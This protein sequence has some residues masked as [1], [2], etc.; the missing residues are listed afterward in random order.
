MIFSHHNAG[1]EG[2][3][4]KIHWNNEQK[5]RNFVRKLCYFIP[6]N[7]AVLTLSL[8]YSIYCVCL[9]NYDTS[10][11]ILQFPLYTPFNK[12]TVIG[13][14]GEWF[15]QFTLSFSYATCMSSLT[16]YFVCCCFYIGTF[17]DHFDEICRLVKGDADQIQHEK[18]PRNYQRIYQRLHKRLGLAVDIHVHLLECVSFFFENL[19]LCS[20]LN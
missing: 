20:I 12:Q 19:D 18:N 4:S 15:I 17:C 3:I 6:L 7:E 1:G 11:W 14:Y 5:C 13:W 16:S 9:G 8:L 2:D 10:K